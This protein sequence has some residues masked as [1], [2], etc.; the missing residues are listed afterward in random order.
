MVG[1]SQDDAALDGLVITTP[2]LIHLVQQFLNS[3]PR[4]QSLLSEVNTTNSQE[5]LPSGHEKMLISYASAYNSTAKAIHS[6]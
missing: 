1:L 5:R 3:F 2:H 6:Q 4:I